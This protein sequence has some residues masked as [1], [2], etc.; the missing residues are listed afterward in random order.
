MIGDGVD[1]FYVLKLLKRLMMLNDSDSDDG[2]DGG[3]C[4]DDDYNI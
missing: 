1:F 2:D 4:S 3:V